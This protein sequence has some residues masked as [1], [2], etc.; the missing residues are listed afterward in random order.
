[1]IPLVVP[2]IRWTL[3]SDSYEPGSPN[4]PLKL[5]VLKL[6]TAWCTHWPFTQRVRLA[7]ILPR[8]HGNAITVT[9]RYKE[10]KAEAVAEAVVM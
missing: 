4:S 6:F 3:V 7:R 1:M 10:D 9:K 8:D 2:D 5:S